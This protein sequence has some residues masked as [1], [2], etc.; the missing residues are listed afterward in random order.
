[1]SNSTSGFVIDSTTDSVAGSITCSIDGSIPASAEKRICEVYDRGI[2]FWKTTG[3]FGDYSVDNSPGA[4]NPE[5]TE[6]VS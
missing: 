5:Y 2:T 1:M 3:H 4:T 6:E